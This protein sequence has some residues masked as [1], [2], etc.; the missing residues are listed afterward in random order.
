[1]QPPGEPARHS[2]SHGFRKQG[3]HLPEEALKE[4]P[5]QQVPGNG[6][7][8]SCEDPVELAQGGFAVGLLARN[9][10]DVLPG[11]ALLPHQAAGKEPPQ[12]HLQAEL[13]C[14]LSS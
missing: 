14:M 10:V 13:T 12:R 11:Q 8:D 4:G 2:H 6:V 5:R 1:M 9:P 7:G 3:E